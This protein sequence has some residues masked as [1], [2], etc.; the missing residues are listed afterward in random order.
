[1]LV[2]APKEQT[3]EQIKNLLYKDFDY[4]FDK[5]YTFLEQEEVD[6]W[7]LIPCF[8]DQ[9]TKLEIDHE[10][11]SSLEKDVLYKIYSMVWHLMET[12][13]TEVVFKLTG[14]EGRMVYTNAWLVDKE[15]FY[16]NLQPQNSSK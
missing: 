3:L 4:Q 8:D 12:H 11:Y 1:M 10:K 5:L 13:A 16:A 6:I 14:D 2:I 7:S 9:L 15:I